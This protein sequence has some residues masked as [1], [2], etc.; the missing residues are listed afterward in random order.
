MKEPLKWITLLLT[1]PITSS[2]TR[3][4][5]NNRATVAIEEGELLGGGD[6]TSS[7]SMVEYWNDPKCFESTEE[8]R[9]AVA[10]YQNKDVYDAQLAQRYGWP[11]GNWC[12]SSIT[13]F[14]NLFTQHRYF[15]EPL[16]QWDMSSATDLSGMFQNCHWFN[17]PLN[18]WDTS[19]VQN[20]QRIFAS[21]RNFNQPLDKWRTESVT[22]TS[23]AFL[24]AFSFSQP[25]SLNGWNIRNVRN[26]EGMFRDARSFD[27][28]LLTWDVDHIENTKS[29]VSS[30]PGVSVNLLRG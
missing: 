5:G 29:M 27:S 6:A 26:A 22:D 20:L 28:T 13:D 25:E 30:I 7:I 10:R 24:H 4:S 15:D 9:A 12:V 14:S 21:A 1:L 17:Q 8:L 3:G 23:Y 19:S 2:Q 16:E 11:I 18:D